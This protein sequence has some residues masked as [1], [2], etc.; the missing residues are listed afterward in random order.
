MPKVI[1]DQFTSM[2]VSRQERYQLR[3]VKALRCRQCGRTELIDTV[4]PR[5]RQKNAE[6]MRLDRVE[7]KRRAAD[8]VYSL[9]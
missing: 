9:I 1:I 5:C 7:A 8:P 3:Q 4:C 2:D 6:R